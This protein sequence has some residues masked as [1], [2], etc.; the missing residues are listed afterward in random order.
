MRVG[1]VL[2]HVGRPQVKLI[3]GFINDI[4]RISS[5]NQY[6]RRLMKAM[7]DRVALC[8]DKENQRHFHF[9]LESLSSCI[10]QLD[11]VLNT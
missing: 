3:S 9:L 4:I 7:E 11:M 6:S 2:L 5:Y 8:Q 1:E 10:S